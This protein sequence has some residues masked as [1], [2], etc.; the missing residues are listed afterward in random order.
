V[1]LF[2]RAGFELENLL[3]LG[4]LVALAALLREESRGTHGRVDYPL[5][6]D[7]HFLGRFHWRQGEGARFEPVGAPIRG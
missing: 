4:E 7:E 5:R 6:D 1:Y 2:G 3:L